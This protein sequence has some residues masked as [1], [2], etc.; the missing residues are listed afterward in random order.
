MLLQVQ[1]FPNNVGAWNPSNGDSSQWM[2]SQR[3]HWI[4]GDSYLEGRFQASPR[5][6]QAHQ[7]RVNRTRDSMP[8]LAKGAQNDAD[9]WMEE[10]VLT[11]FVPD[12]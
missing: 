8:G 3:P 1:I 5:R 2:K 10:V 6:K 11:V 4:Q 9:V 7:A 12:W